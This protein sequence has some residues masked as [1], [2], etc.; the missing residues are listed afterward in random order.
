MWGSKNKS[1]KVSDFYQGENI[2]SQLKNSLFGQ[3]EKIFENVFSDNTKEQYQLPKVV[4][5][6][7]ES[8]GKSSLLERITKC[9]IFPRDGKLCTKC[10][11]KVKLVCANNSDK[12]TNGSYSVQLPGKP[13]KIL[14]D[15]KEIYPIVQK[16][17]NDLPNDIISQ[18]EIIINIIDKDVPNFEFYDLPG[19]RTYPPE[20]ATMT[21]NIC[22]KYL[23]DKNSIVLCV[24]PGTTTRLTSC[25][26][27]ALIKETKME[28]NTILALTMIDRLQQENIEE[29]LIN[30]IIDKSDEI[31]GL[32]FANYIAVVNRSHSDKYSLE[33]SDK[34]EKEWF[35]LNI[36]SCIPPEFKKHK[37]KII[38]R[39][40]LSNLVKNMDDLYNQFIQTDW[41]PRMLTEMHS[42][43]GKIKEETKALGIIITEKNFP[44]L[45][46]LFQDYKTRCAKSVGAKSVGA[47]SAGATG[48]FIGG[49]FIGFGLK[50][51][52]ANDLFEKTELCISV[53]VDN[54]VKKYGVEYIL[55]IGDTLQPSLYDQS[56]FEALGKITG[57]NYHCGPN[58][59]TS[60]NYAGQFYGT[61]ELIGFYD[62]IF[63]NLND[64][65]E[66][67][68]V[69]KNTLFNKPISSFANLSKNL[70]EVLKIYVKQ[71]FNDNMLEIAKRKVVDEIIS[72][73]IANNGVT[74][75]EFKAVFAYFIKLIRMIM[76]NYHAQVC[77]FIVHNLT[78]DY[79]AESD[80]WKEKRSKLEAEKNEIESNITKINDLSQVLPPKTQIDELKKM[81]K[82]DKK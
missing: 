35:D 46:K 42:R 47:I 33:E 37:D 10:P 18:D 44:E 3:I 29:L 36:Y 13:V 16:Y 52:S 51:I 30:R 54:S 60:G 49:D 1:T 28:H 5:I 77:D 12:N 76:G 40:R 20:A 80:E 23:S 15:K 78:I 65:I 32:H 69:L 9:Q 72:T 39:T 67:R 74:A 66:F 38:C 58:Q 34:L 64:R 43:E 26:S 55:G 62:Q 41:I 31:E 25:Q 17:M 7:T 53:L 71:R 4:V 6:G 59:I 21:V 8:S 61:Y 73:C 48:D 82:N 14:K 70:D 45:L 68:Y 11:I 50:P 81:I 27:I 22:K 57:L 24:V 2:F 19:I 56:Y 75:D 79:F 63:S